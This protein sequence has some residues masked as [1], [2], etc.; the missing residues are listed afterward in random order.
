M[1]PKFWKLVKIK[2]KENAR[3]NTIYLF[4]I[5][6]RTSDL[7]SRITKGLWEWN[8]RQGIFLSAFLQLMTCVP[9][10]IFNVFSFSSAQS[11]LVGST[12][13]TYYVCTIYLDSFAAANLLG[14]DRLPVCLPALL[15]VVERLLCLLVTIDWLTDWL[16]ITISGSLL[17]TNAEDFSISK[18][19]GD[20][21][22]TSRLMMKKKRGEMPEFVGQ[23]RVE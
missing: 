18:Q 13:R 2:R 23:F 1:S 19:G 5:F 7:D 17:L 8:S 14:R 16:W 4:R 9:I 21:G 6:R 3:N 15:A 22:V 10:F 20:Q 12:V 11:S